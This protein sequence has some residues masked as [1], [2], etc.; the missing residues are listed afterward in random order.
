V[1]DHVAAYEQHFRCFLIDN[2]GAGDSD[3]PPGPTRPDDGED[4]AQV[5]QSL[6]IEQARWWPASRWA[7]SPAALAPSPRLLDP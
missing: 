3:Q 6:G 4:T 7:A 1:A 2:R 5:M